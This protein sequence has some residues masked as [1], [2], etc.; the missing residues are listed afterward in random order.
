MG[1][2]TRK[3]QRLRDDE[4]VTLGVLIHDCVREAV[5]QLVQEELTIALGALKYQRSYERSGYRNGTRV[6]PR[7]APVRSEAMA[8]WNYERDAGA[9]SCGSGMVSPLRAARVA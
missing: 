1:E 9:T 6:S 2:R 4:P 7:P 3:L 5:E 8:R